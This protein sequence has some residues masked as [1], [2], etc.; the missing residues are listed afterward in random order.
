[1]GEVSET[2]SRET[3]EGIQKKI[4]CKIPGEISVKFWRNFW[5]NPSNDFTG[6]IYKGSNGNI[7]AGTA[8]EI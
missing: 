4:A 5:K 6:G 1:M 3:S 2:F 8:S 7:P